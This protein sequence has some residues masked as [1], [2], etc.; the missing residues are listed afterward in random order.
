[1]LNDQEHMKS[2]PISNQIYKMAHYLNELA[3]LKL[4]KPYE[5]RWSTIYMKV[6]HVAVTVYD[7]E[8]VK[9]HLEKYGKA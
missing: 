1:M 4:I 6:N 5:G 7:Q 8:Y 3:N 2:Y 9:F